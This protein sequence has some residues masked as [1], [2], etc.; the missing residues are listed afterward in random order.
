MFTFD[1][2][3]SGGGFQFGGAGGFGA[4]NNASGV[5]TFGA[6][7]AASPAPPANPSIAPQQGTPGGGFNFTQPPAF[8]IGYAAVVLIQYWMFWIVFVVLLIMGN[9][10]ALLPGRLNPSLPLQLDRK[11]LLGVRSRQRCG[12]E[13]RTLWPRQ[14]NRL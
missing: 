11:Q 14:D 13:S 1:L 8:N 12:A 5:F 6:G 2:F 7:S 4:T 9:V 3:S 10:S